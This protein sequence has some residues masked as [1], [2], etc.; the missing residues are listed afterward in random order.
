MQPAGRIAQSRQLNSCIGLIYYVSG[1]LFFQRKYLLFIVTVC[2]ALVGQGNVTILS[3]GVNLSYQPGI[4]LIIIIL[5]LI[6]LF[7]L[8]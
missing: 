7:I 6:Q 1:V 3:S 4:E 8:H 2:V 5:Q